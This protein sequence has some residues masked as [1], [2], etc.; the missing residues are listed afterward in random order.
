MVKTKRTSA[1]QISIAMNLL[2]IGLAV[3][4][5]P[6]RAQGSGVWTNTGSMN[7]G[8]AFQYVHAA[9]QWAGAGGRRRR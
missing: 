2:A 1:F 4:S 8:R 5:P 7:V 9:G 3:N 6:A